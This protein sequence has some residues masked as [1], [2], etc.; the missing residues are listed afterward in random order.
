MAEENEILLF[1]LSLFVGGG[2]FADVLDVDPHGLLREYV[3]PPGEGLQ[4]DGGMAVV[5]RGDKDSVESAGGEHLRGGVIGLAAVFFSQPIG[6]VF[7]HVADAGQFGLV[8]FIDVGAVAGA[9]IAQAD[10]GQ[11]NFF[12][13]L[14][15]LYGRVSGSVQLDRGR[16]TG[17]REKCDW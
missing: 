3:H 6:F 8:Q 16:E 13:S 12:H 15:P 11:L 14:S 1:F 9:H 5:G 2:H 17:D 4:G 7:D 10:D